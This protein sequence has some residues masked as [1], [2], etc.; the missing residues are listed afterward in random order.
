MRFTVTLSLAAALMAT[1]ALSAQA[2]TAH[3]A[4]ATPSLDK[5]I[6]AWL[7]GDTLNATTAAEVN[8]RCD[9]ALKIATDAKTALEARKGPAT[10]KGDYAA[11]DSLQLILGDAGSEIYLVTQ[12]SPSKDVRDAAN[13]CVPKL[14]DLGTQVSLSRPI[15]DRLS[16]IPQKGLDDKTSYTLNHQLTEYKLSGVDKDDA[17]RA[18]VTELQKEI[19]ETGLKFDNNINADK[20]DVAFKPEELAGLPQDFIDAHKPGADGM[21]HLTVDY[22]DAIPVLTYASIRDTR[23]KMMVAYSNRGYPQNEQ[24]LTDLVKERYD[25]AQTLG[26]PDYATDVTADKMIGNPDRAQAFLEEV[27]TAAKPGADAD[28]AELLAFAK[29]MDPSIDK[30]ERYDGTYFSNLLKKQKYSVDGAEVRKYFTRDKAEAG[31]FKLVG[32]LFDADIRPWKTKVWSPDVTAWELYDHGKLV[33]RFYLD[34]SPRDGKYNHEAQ[35]PIRTGVEG[36]Q[37]PVGA[38]LCNFPATG[39]MEHGDVTTFL[40]EFGHLIHNMY[41]GHT[42]YA[43]QSMGNLQWDFIEAPSQLLEEWTFDYDTLKGFAS[44][45][46]G[47]P[48]PEDLVKKMN[49]ARQFGEASQWKTQIAYSAISMD[50][51][52]QKP[53]FDL[54]QTFNNDIAKYSMYPP[55]DGTHSQDSFG[56]LNGYS[57]IYYTYVWSKAIA[58]DLFTRFKADG[59]RNK[60]TAMRYRK[61]VLEPGGSED[62]N[63]LI[64][65]FLGRPLSLDAFKDELAKKQ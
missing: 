24:V 30:L 33:G 21:I 3:H 43:T 17:V 62:A 19:T 1:T 8:A 40:H 25:L 54:T 16:A 35:F 31:I 15:Y 39:P 11:Y 9:S 34:L 56:H 46:K 6:D 53:G 14:S 42:Q 7:A 65:N 13:A 18:K 37:V 36:R 41:S 51:Y 10:V 5:R 60:D 59:M 47:N 44:D 61:L 50:Y 32:D 48:I 57:A 29:T 52:H 26:F 55:I 23:K 58:L 49:A 20:G 28:Y 63:L 22:P 4:A 38:L 64:Q 27:N 45:D 12:S 2:A